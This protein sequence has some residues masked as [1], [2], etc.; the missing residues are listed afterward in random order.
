[1]LVHLLLLASLAGPQ[2][3]PLAPGTVAGTVQTASLPKA[4]SGQ[5]APTLPLP[6]VPTSGPGWDG[7]WGIIISECDLRSGDI[8]GDTVGDLCDNCRH[9]ANPDQADSDSDLIGD[10]CDSCPDDFDPSGT[11][12]DGDGVGDAC[13]SE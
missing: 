4:P 5:L 11:D 10:A 2:A 3:A 6:R 13:D 12:S 8:D 9:V 1:M 7:G